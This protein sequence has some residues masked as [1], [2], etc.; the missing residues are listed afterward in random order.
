MTRFKKFKYRTMIF[1]EI[2]DLDLLGSEGWESIHIIS[3]KDE[4]DDDGEENEEGI[5][6]VSVTTG[7]FKRETLLIGH[8]VKF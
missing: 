5:P 4:V 7:L 6:V 3:T 1:R 2:G 8:S